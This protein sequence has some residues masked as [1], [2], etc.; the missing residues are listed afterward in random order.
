MFL[1]IFL[2]ALSTVGSGQWVKQTVD[3]TASF[4]GLSVV[5]EKV[6][7]ASGTGGTVIRTTDGGKTWKVMT[8]PGAEKLDFRDI[9]AFDAKTAYILSIGNGEASRIYKTTDGGL[10]WKLQFKANDPKLFFD[11]LACKNSLKCFA[12]ADPVNNSFPL[13]VTA[14]GGEHWQFWPVWFPQTAEGEA[15]F[16]ASGTCL[17]LYRSGKSDVIAIVSGGTS[18]SIYQMPVDSPSLDF[19]S[20]DTPIIR[21]TP[22]SGIFSIAMRDSRNGVIVG[23][24]YEKPNEATE[25]L[26][27]TNDGGVTWTLGT[28]L[29]GY[30]S[31]VAYIDKK[32]IIAVGTNGTDLSTDVGK[33]WSKIGSENLNAVAAKGKK[34]VWAVGPAGMVT[35]LKL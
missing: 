25:N 11:A 12:M 24:N 21:G 22:G 2:L 18:S 27:F 30:R 14:D 28:G 19:V 20:Y 1:S 16:A 29:S 13:I 10:N 5:N 35:K 34:A 32:N 6:V 17:I 3:T 8:V 4:R 9:E 23:G 15:S 26:A 33:T 31:A 7:W